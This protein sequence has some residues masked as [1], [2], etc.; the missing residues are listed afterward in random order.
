MIAATRQF[1]LATILF[2]GGT[3]ARG[4]ETY[5]VDPVHSSISFMIS[6]VGISNIHGRFNDFSGTI[7]ID[8]ADPGQVVVRVV[9]SDQ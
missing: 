1:T 5:T 8:Q 9:H 3:V 6:H 2:A 4:A 7:T